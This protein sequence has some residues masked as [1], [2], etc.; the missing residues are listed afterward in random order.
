M[1]A[2][3]YTITVTPSNGA[4]NAL[5]TINITE[6]T[7]M[8]VLSQNIDSAMCGSASGSIAVV[9][10]GGTAPYQYLWSPSGGTAATANN[11]TPAI[12]HLM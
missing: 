7:A 8:S 2:G 6:P 3:T 10:T 11:L 5:A 9:M 1:L 4:C 12:T